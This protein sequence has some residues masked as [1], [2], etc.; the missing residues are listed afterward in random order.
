MPGVRPRFVR[1]GERYRRPE[2][3][4]WRSLSYLLALFFFLFFLLLVPIIPFSLGLAFLSNSP[5]PA[6]ASFLVS[7]QFSR[8]HSFHRDYQHSF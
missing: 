8:C 1:L 3:Y 6:S 5:P 4:H 7:P 2:P